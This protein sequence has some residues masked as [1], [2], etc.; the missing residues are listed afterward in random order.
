M[1]NSINKIFVF[2]DK[3][4]GNSQRY[5]DAYA[6]ADLPRD[7]EYYNKIAFLEETGEIVTHGKV[8]ALNTEEDLSTISTKLNF[9]LNLVGD[10]DNSGDIGLNENSLVSRVESLETL[11]TN[12]SETEDN[13]IID[14]LTDIINWF[15]GLEE[16]N[17]V[18]QLM[19]DIS[20]NKIAIGTKR[21]ETNNATGLYKYIDDKIES[22]TL[23]DSTV[24]S[25]ELTNGKHV[26]VTIFETAGRISSVSLNENDIASKSALDE[27]A[28]F[29]GKAGDEFVPTLAARVTYLE[30]ASLD[31]KGVEDEELI[32]VTGDKQIT[33][34]STQELKD[35]VKNA[36]TAVQS[37]N[38]T[39]YL[40]NVTYNGT[41]Y[42]LAPVTG[43]IRIESGE[44]AYN[45]NDQ[46]KLA[47]VGNVINTLNGLQLWENYS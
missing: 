17:T 25:G 44:L 32:S 11:V 16:G 30:N 29:V 20:Q 39:D 42:T 6:R 8:F 36:N 13:N 3:S 19:S 28:A 31:V 21:T 38:G 33:I 35:A 9:L 24:N 2:V 37:I 40:L 27:L 10:T 45:P 7:N 14:R 41:T 43:T 1:L 18:T 15:N 4:E 34:Q 12:I 26:K 5:K 46:Y 22:V 47:T 23:S